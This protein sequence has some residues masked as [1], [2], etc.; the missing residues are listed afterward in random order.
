MS[1]SVDQWSK[2]CHQST[3]LCGNSLP[4]NYCTGQ[5]PCSGGSVGD[6]GIMGKTAA[7]IDASQTK[8]WG[9]HT[10]EGGIELVGVGMLAAAGL[11]PGD[12]LIAVEGF[13]FSERND[14]RTILTWQFYTE[15]IAVTFIRKGR[16]HSSSMDNPKGK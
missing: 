2:E 10:K 9:P 8:F 16:M 15:K 14:R 1:S 7:E 6:L 4:T 11:Q 5:Q 13:R 12:I 3:G